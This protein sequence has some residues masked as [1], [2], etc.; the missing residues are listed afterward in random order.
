ML[1]VMAKLFIKRLSSF[2][3]QK[4]QERKSA[5]GKLSYNDKD[6]AKLSQILVMD[7]MSSEESD[8]DLLQVKPLP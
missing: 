1:I 5:F 2:S 8:D 6:K 3:M 7:M 4:L